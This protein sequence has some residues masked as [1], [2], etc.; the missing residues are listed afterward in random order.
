MKK[1]IGVLIY[2]DQYDILLQKRSANK[3]SYPN[4]WALL[5]GHVEEGETVEIAAI[6]ECKEELGIEVGM[7]ELHPF[8]TIK[9]SETHTTY[10]FYVRCN[11]DEAG[12]IFQEE[13]LSQVKWYSINDVINMI[14][15]H[16]EA[17]VYKKDKIELFQ[18]F[19]KRLEQLK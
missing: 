14:K 12:F 5:H 3:R 6:R 11:K 19:Q 18:N 4:R 17:I 10:Y 9:N 7:S 1:E 2:N 15:N 13:E 16:G 8:T